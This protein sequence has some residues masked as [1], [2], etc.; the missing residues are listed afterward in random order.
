MGHTLNIAGGFKDGDDTIVELL[1]PIPHMLPDM[2]RSN[3]RVMQ[4]A[5]QL[6]A[7]RLLR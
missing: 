3:G 7:L 6:F 4:L 2:D 5:T 1:F